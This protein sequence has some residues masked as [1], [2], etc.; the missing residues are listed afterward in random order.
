[1][2]LYLHFWN[3]RFEIYF[4]NILLRDNSNCEQ[5]NNLLFLSSPRGHGTYY[6]PLIKNIII[7]RFHSNRP[8]CFSFVIIVYTVQCPM[9]CG[10]ESKFKLSPQSTVRHEQQQARNLTEINL[11]KLTL[12]ALLPSLK[13][14]LS[15]CGFI[16]TS[17]SIYLNREELRL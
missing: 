16:N 2:H 15:D 8:N 14:F 10:V 5:I 1:M 12:S 13:F 17:I 6:N 9:W 11:T 4:R 7:F 3:Q